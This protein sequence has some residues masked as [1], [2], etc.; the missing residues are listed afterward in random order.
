MTKQRT[1]V[2]SVYTTRDRPGIWLGYGK[3]SA[4]I[5]ATVFF[6]GV[7]MSKE[8]KNYDFRE[9]SCTNSKTVQATAVVRVEDE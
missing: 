9:M 8:Y 7:A 2:Q 4:K 3:S 6:Q 5:F 1:F